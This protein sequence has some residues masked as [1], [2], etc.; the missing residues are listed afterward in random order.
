[1]NFDIPT[2]SVKEYLEAFHTKME[3]VDKAAGKP[4]FTKAY[5]I[6]KAV[7][8]SCMEMEDERS[9]LGQLHCIMNTA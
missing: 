7:K 9:H 2:K 1:M 6:V 3:E 8:D 5:R 4:T